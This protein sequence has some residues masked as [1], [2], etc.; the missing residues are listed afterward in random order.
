MALSINFSKFCLFTVHEELSLLF[1]CVSASVVCNLTREKCEEKQHCW[2]VHLQLCI[3]LGE[4]IEWEM[5]E[6]NGRRLV[7]FKPLLML[8]ELTAS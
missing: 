5:W 4:K 8:Q 3:K 6:I 2:K 7:L 1:V